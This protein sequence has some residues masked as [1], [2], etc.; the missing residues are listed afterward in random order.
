M[1][2]LLNESRGI[3]VI[4]E[5]SKIEILKMGGIKQSLNLDEIFVLF[6]LFF[7]MFNE[8]IGIYILDL[9]K[10]KVLLVNGGLVCDLENFVDGVVQEF[11]YNI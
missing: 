4:D 6:V 2:R 11:E 10:N 1:M 3:Q 8:D 5:L 9:V 7:F